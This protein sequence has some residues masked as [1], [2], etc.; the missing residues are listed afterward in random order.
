MMRD[1]NPD[2]TPLRLIAEAIVT[3]SPTA[4]VIDRVSQNNIYDG[5]ALFM[6]VGA[7]GITFN[8][9]NYIA[10]KL[11]DS[12]DNATYANVDA[13][14]VNYGAANPIGTNFAQ[15]VDV[16]G[17]VR[18]INAAK[19]SAD[20]TP[21]KVSYV[22]N[23]RYVRATPVLGGTHATGTLVGLSGVLGFPRLIPAN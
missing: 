9:A 14:D 10:L 13:T 23:K 12:D 1:M 4:V 19:G 5:L 16:N 11:E 15:A 20:A 18:L 21:F 6:H 17:F 7:G 3:T 22:G 2:I 8:G